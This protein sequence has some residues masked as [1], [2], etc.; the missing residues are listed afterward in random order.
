M[1]LFFMTDLASAFLQVRP[2]LYTT[3]PMYQVNLMIVF[4]L[5]NC[6]LLPALSAVS[7]VSSTLAAVEKEN[8]KS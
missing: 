2:V 6:G 1:Y 3:E 7:S 4:I 5:A 8:S